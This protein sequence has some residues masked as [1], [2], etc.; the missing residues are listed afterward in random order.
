MTGRTKYVT[1]ASIS[2]KHATALVLV[3]A[4]TLVMTLGGSARA[5]ERGAEASGDTSKA[6]PQEQALED[7]EDAPQALRAAQPAEPAMQ[8][9]PVDH[10]GVRA[11]ADVVA[12]ALRIGEITTN[13]PQ[14]VIN[15]DDPKVSNIEVDGTSLTSVT[16]Q[17][18]GEYN[19]T[20]SNLTVVI[21]DTGEIVQYAETLVLESSAGTFDVRSYADGDRV[22]AEQTDIP[23]ATDAELSREL[24]AGIGEVHASTQDGMSTMQSGGS[25]AQ[26]LAVALGIGGLTAAVIAAICKGACVAVATPPG[27]AVCAACIGGIVALGTGTGMNAVNCFR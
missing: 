9:T 5:L 7:C 19:S 21:D 26:C 6:A 17:I 2:M 10:E 24:N 11:R 12:A 16:Y 4:L 14:D 23:Y 20:L 13:A 22:M 25:T 1:L 15:T 3:I 27:A 18:G 8:V